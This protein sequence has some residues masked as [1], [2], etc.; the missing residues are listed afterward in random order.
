SRRGPRRADATCGKRH[1]RD[2]P[3]DGAHGGRGRPARPL[4]RKAPSPPAA[5]EGIGALKTERR[6]MKKKSETFTRLDATADGLL[7]S[8]ARGDDA[9]LWIRARWS[10][11]VG[12][13]LSRKIEPAALAGRRLPLRV[14]DPAWRK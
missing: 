2:P 4:G 7:R 13:P 9:L 8:L 6:A 12:E 10:R 11:I 14:L 5:G 1:A 3:G